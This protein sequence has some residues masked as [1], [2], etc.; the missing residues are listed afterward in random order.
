MDNKVFWF[1]VAY[2]IILVGL[3]LCLIFGREIVWHDWIVGLA[4]GM[5]VS[6]LL[7]TFGK[8]RRK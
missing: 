4:Y 3:T 5:A 6:G 8:R 7:G 1:R 2:I